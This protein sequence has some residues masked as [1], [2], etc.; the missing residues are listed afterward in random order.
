[1]SRW[2][3]WMRWFGIHLGVGALGMAGIAGW[4]AG[5]TM[6]QRV[7]ALH[8]FW[9]TAIFLELAGF[10]L[11]GLLGGG[12]A[13]VLGFRGRRAW[14]WGLGSGLGGAVGLLGIVGAGVTIGPGLFSS[15]L[16]WFSGMELT[17]GLAGLGLFWGLGVGMVQ[18]W[19]GRRGMG[20]GWG[21]LSGLGGLV[22]GWGIG[23]LLMRLS[24]RWLERG[25]LIDWIGTGMLGGGLFGLLT[26]LGLS[27]LHGVREERPWL[28]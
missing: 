28:M 14:A 9:D 10:W 21:M 2:G 24:E 1:M 6:L 3:V 20:W 13:W 25:E 15:L 22:G 26:A 23:L 16:G 5:W 8:G 11:G 4:D 7:V 19:M 12:Q 18:G 17:V 27:E